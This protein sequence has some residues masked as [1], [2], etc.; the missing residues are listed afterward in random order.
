M[1]TIPTNLY[2]FQC[3]LRRERHDAGAGNTISA[4]AREGM[5]SGDEQETRGCAGD[6]TDHEAATRGGGMGNEGPKRRR[7]WP[8]KR[9]GNMRWMQHGRQ[10]QLKGVAYYPGVPRRQSENLIQPAVLRLRRRRHSGQRKV[11]TDQHLDQAIS[12]PRRPTAPQMD[13]LV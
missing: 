1:I 3:N 8:K 13:S 7:E 11:I 4:G 9:E 10:W 2:N 12:R 6:G 5:V